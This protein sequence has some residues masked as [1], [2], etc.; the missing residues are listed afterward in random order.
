MILRNFIAALPLLA[1]L[2]ALPAH[3]AHAA[4]PPAG[5]I[6]SVD[7]LPAVIRTP[8]TWCLSHDL[9]TTITKGEAIT[10]DADHVVL[11]CRG[12]R[13]SPRVVNRAFSVTGIISR[14]RD[15]IA[16]KNCGVENL[17][18]GILL[19]G[20]ARHQVSH[21][22]VE[23]SSSIG[24]GIVGDNS[25]IESNSVLDAGGPGPEDAYGI[26][27][28][29][30]VDI[31]DNYVGGVNTAYDPTR[32]SR[33]STA[34]SSPSPYGPATIA[35]N[36]IHG[37]FKVGTTSF[38]YAIEAEGG[39]TNVHDNDVST[40]SDGNYGIY[41]SQAGNIASGNILN[42]FPTPVANCTSLGNIIRP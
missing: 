22:R 15:D 34:I 5:C 17:H 20:G 11:D 30:V 31:L 10:I 3:Q 27:G 25:V 29:G 42:G 37:L 24:I 9:T 13:I 40:V 23:H 19:Y 16:V 38:S 36:R 4:N 21:N 41:C 35:R 14:D 2:T 28:Q 7:A 33:Y 32:P 18:V 8:G 6:G 12:Y 26:I 39:G 1:A